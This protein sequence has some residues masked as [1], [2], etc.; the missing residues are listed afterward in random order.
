M[1]FL[2]CHCVLSIL[3]RNAAAFN[4]LLQRKNN[5]PPP[6]GEGR[7]GRQQYDRLEFY[8]LLLDFFAVENPKTG[9]AMISIIPKILT[10]ISGSSH[11]ITL[12]PTSISVTTPIISKLIDHIALTFFESIFLPPQIPICRSS[13][14]YQIPRW[15]STADE[16]GG[17][18]EREKA[19]VSVL[20]FFLSVCYHLLLCALRNTAPPAGG[21]LSILSRNGSTS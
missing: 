17:G 3:T 10:A 18:D 12:A 21:S 13:V 9:S 2:S 5:L 19:P 6:P 1:A 8:L 7:F 16:G 14:F 15:T 4:A 11:P 20:D